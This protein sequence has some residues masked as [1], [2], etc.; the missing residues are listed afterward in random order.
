MI[1]KFSSDEID[2]LDLFLVIWKNKWRVIFIALIIMVI[3]IIFQSNK[4][5]G[6]VLATTEIRPISVYDEAKYKIYNAFTK[7]VS[8]DNKRSFPKMKLTENNTESF[9]LKDQNYDS[10]TELTIKNLDINNI[11]KDFL[12]ELFLEK[13]E[14]K[15]NLSESLKKFN[16]IKKE[17][18]SNGV[19]YNEA[20]LDLAS[21]IS[22]NKIESENEKSVTKEVS[23]IVIQYKG[24]DLQNWENFLKFI[25]KETNLKI[26]QKLSEMFIN[27][28]EYVKTIKKFRIEDIESEIK[29][30]SSDFEKDLLNEKK[31]FLN[32]NKYIE[33]MQNIFSNSPISN[34]ENFYAA[35]I[36]YEST[37]Y[38]TKKKT[39]LKTLVFVGGIFGLI[40]GM[41]Y[42]LVVNAVQSRK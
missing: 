18:F 7:E 32:Q 12:F 28:I 41:L 37:I 30:A 5:P 2:I 17:D 11:N 8:F 35:K 39:S 22:F 42:V 15:S 29:T 1:K 31:N 14:Q 25:E 4:K 36:I 9:I 3:T 10:L 20:I 19:E 27:Y 6:K 23:P 38:K 33:R 34:S 21:S 26:Q 13:I 16:F 24:H 40:F